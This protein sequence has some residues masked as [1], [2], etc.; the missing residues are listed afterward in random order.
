MVDLI[1]W[2]GRQRAYLV[3]ALGVFPALAAPRADLLGAKNAWT[4]SLTGGHCAG[5]QGAGFTLQLSS[6]DAPSASV[7]DLLVDAPSLPS[8]NMRFG[9]TRRRGDWIPG[10]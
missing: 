7:E 6:N 10:D 4:L 5:R 3:G 8:S 2:G 1:G 9:K